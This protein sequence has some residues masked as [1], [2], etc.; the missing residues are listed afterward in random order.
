MTTV[1]TTWTRRPG[2]YA[3]Y[4]GVVVGTD[5][6]AVLTDITCGDYELRIRD[7]SGEKLFHDYASGFSTVSLAQAWAEREIDKVLHPQNYA[8][9]TYQ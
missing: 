6:T 4:D 5:L 7:S 2:E 3:I 8:T 9:P 1:K